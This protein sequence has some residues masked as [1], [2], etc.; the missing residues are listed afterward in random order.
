MI[1]RSTINYFKNK[2]TKPH[3]RNIS[4]QTYHSS[5]RVCAVAVMHTH[6]SP[7]HTCTYADITIP[8][9]IKA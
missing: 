5:S 4:P 1:A 2:D 3:K 8:A 6:V 9:A 7:S